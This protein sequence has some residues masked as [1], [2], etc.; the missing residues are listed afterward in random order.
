MS[1]QLKNF[2][3]KLSKA[4]LHVQFKVNLKVIWRL[5]HGQ[6]I[7]LMKFLPNFNF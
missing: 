6:I 1:F 5:F 3:K 2:E 7:F 4:I